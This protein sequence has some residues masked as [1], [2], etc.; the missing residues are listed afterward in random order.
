[1]ADFWST[2]L[3]TGT[4]LS[5]PSYLWCRLGF[6]GLDFVLSGLL[7]VTD[8]LHGRSGVFQ[9]AVVATVDRVWLGI[10]LAA[11]TDALGKG[12]LLA[13]LLHNLFLGRL[14]RRCR[15]HFYIRG[16]LLLGVRYRLL[17]C[18]LLFRGRF[19]TF[20]FNRLL[21]A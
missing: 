4:V 13:G 17:R 19:L 12:S 20:W 7:V 14:P 5:A 6:L 18:C 16:H 11:R 3:Q 21:Q 2:K 10:V 9:D 1:M 15:F 8:G